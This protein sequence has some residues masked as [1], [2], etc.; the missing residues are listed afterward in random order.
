MGIRLCLQEP[1]KIRVLSPLFGFA[2]N[3][4]ITPDDSMFYY[5]F[6]K[7]AK[8]C[9][10]IIVDTI[11]EAEKICEFEDTNDAGKS[12]NIIGS[13]DRTGRYTRR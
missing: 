4:I 12:K 9:A 10:T 11:K 8:S 13:R 1:K 6:S 3:D 7:W 2:V 5:Q